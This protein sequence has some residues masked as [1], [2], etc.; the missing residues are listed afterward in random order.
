MELGNIGIILNEF[1]DTC[2]EDEQWIYLTT[3]V[4]VTDYWEKTLPNR[5]LSTKTFYEIRYRLLEACTPF[6]C[7]AIYLEETVVPDTLVSDSVDHKMS[8]ENTDRWKYHK[9]LLTIDEKT[10]VRYLHERCLRYFTWYDKA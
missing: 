8:K 6:V 7:T 4:D 2:A 3:I 10:E 5:M 1:F 9:V